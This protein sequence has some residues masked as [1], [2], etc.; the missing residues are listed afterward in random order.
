MKN[1]KLIRDGV[2]GKL[3]GFTEQ[4][5]PEK[6]IES[7]TAKMGEET[8]EFIDELFSGREEGIINSYIELGDLIQVMVCLT[9]YVQNLPESVV[10]NETLT[11]MQDKSDKLGTFK[12]KMLLDVDAYKE[13]IKVKQS[14]NINK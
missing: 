11:R 5:P 7:F 10:L 6:I 9:A 8:Q 1:T 12:A 4:C 14:F 13:S 2:A 3:Y